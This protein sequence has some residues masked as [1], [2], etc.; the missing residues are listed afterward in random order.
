MSIYADHNDIKIYTISFAQ[1][2]PQSERDALTILANSTGG[3]YRHAPTAQELTEVYGIIA[4]DLRKHAG[5][6]TTSDVSFE[7][8]MV[9]NVT[10]PG[11]DT[12][13]Y[14]YVDGISTC[15]KR[16]KTGF[17][18]TINTTFNDTLNW[19][20]HHSFNFNVGTIDI[21]DNWQVTFRL[22]V[23]QEGD[24]H[25]FDPDS[26]ITFDDGTKSLKI[27]DTVI[28]AIA[29]LR[30][31]S[32]ESGEFYEEGIN[33]TQISPTRYEWTWNRTYTGGMPVQEYYFISL[34]GGY[35]WTLVGET[36]L[37]EEEARNDVIGHISYD[38]QNLL[39]HGADLAGVTVDFKIKA[40]AIDAASPRTPRGPQI[41]RLPTNLT[42]I[43]LE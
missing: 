40:Y 17:S 25:V 13:D 9:K 42:Y 3:F 37:D 30:N 8:V 35:Q 31:E 39:P 27:P 11:A 5:V 28:N 18:P 22:Q 2:I 20:S 32:F 34:D 16:W 26:I 29:N 10:V 14:Q 1:T 23:L 33:V 41:V 24:I 7:N 38:I 19:I 6:N 12:F 36:I 15:I 4:G 43:T 21:N